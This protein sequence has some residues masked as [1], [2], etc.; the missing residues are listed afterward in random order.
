MRIRSVTVRRKRNLGNY[1]NTDAEVTAELAPGDKPLRVL[2]DL[3]ALCRQHLGQLSQE[4]EQAQETLRPV[5]ELERRAAHFHA[6][7]QAHL[8]RIQEQQD[9]AQLAVLCCDGRARAR[10][11]DSA[12][13]AHKAAEETRV[14]AAGAAA[15]LRREEQRAEVQAARAL[16]R[17]LPWAVPPLP[18]LPALHTLGAERPAAPEPL[19]EDGD[20][21]TF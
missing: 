10:A 2:R 21:L 4:E 7:L 13:A 14:S 3:D 8:S 6:A 19:P 9:K 1:E 20:A 16:L 12:A 5:L 18:A 17:I 15:Q 11:E